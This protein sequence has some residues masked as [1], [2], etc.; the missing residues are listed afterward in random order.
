MAQQ[1]S[2]ALGVSSKFFLSFHEEWRKSALEA[3]AGA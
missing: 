2:D 3:E 1:L